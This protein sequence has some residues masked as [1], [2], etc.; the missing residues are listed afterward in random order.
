M[1]AHRL[2]HT[3]SF[4]GPTVHRPFHSELLPQRPPLF[5][6]ILST[7]LAIWFGTIRDSTVSLAET[8]WCARENN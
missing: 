5:A 3:L 1:T 4:H 6:H 8:L 7:S 2:R